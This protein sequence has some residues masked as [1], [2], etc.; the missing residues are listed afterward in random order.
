MQKGI[1][2]ASAVVHYGIGTARFIQNQL[3]SDAFIYHRFIR[4]VN[5]GFSDVIF[6]GSRRNTVGQII[7]PCSGFTFIPRFIRI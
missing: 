5:F 6:N 4:I 7:D 1:A 3:C 2:A